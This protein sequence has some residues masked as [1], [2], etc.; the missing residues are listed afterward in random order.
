MLTFRSDDG[1]TR[2]GDR[3]TPQDP[4][5]APPHVVEAPGTVH[6]QTSG[7]EAR[8]KQDR[9]RDALRDV[10]R[11]EQARAM[12][13][14]HEQEEARA[15]QAGTGQE[16]Q[17]DAGATG[18]DQDQGA[19][20]INARLQGQLDKHVA[21]LTALSEAD[22]A[23]EIERG[24]ERTIRSFGSREAAEAAGAEVTQALE[25]ADPSGESLKAARNA[26]LEADPRLFGELVAWARNILR[27]H[28]A[29]QEG[30]PSLL[31]R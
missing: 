4:G 25:L 28:Q 2:P 3:L 15:A 30:G 27:Q 6:S 31:N 22:R 26:M 7:E 24:L 10:P 11:H 23:G 19:A 18:A 5:W 8:A 16:G 1:N 20:D 14:F 29:A 13:R 21:R 12:R 9:M 17:G